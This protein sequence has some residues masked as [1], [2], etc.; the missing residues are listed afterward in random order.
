MFVISRAGAV[1]SLLLLLMGCGQSSE[2]DAD[3][4]A[5]SDA[6]ADCESCQYVL[7]GL[8]RPNRLW[9]AA[10]YLYVEDWSAQALI[11]L[12]LAG[13]CGSRQA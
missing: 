5:V 6:S 7:R 13:G 8:Q 12:P 9:V 11:R 3:E 4:M 10:T 2:G 1:G